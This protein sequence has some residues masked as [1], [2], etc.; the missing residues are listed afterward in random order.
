MSVRTFHITSVQKYQ[1]I[2]GVAKGK[3]GLGGNN[4]CLLMEREGDC[5]QSHE[6]P[7]AAVVFIAGEKSCRRQE[8][9]EGLI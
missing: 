3:K 4:L 1:K 2:K 6:A 9:R 7:L 8:G 5:I